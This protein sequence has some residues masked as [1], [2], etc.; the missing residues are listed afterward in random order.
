MPGLAGVSWQEMGG[1]SRDKIERREGR[2]EEMGEIGKV[3]PFLSHIPIGLRF[4]V[5]V[6]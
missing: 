2:E 6:C 4:K 3:A 5:Y 1:K